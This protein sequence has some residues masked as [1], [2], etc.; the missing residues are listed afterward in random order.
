[1]N[2]YL[3]FGTFVG[4]VIGY[5]HAYYIY[6]QEVREIPEALIERPVATRAIAGYYALWTFL[7][8]VVFGSY[9][10]SFWIVSCIAYLIYR[11][12]QTSSTV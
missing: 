8:W 11:T 1:M 4:A 6:R 10:L 2:L 7:L 12:F 5:L 9:M 3:L